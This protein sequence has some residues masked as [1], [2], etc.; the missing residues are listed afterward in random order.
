MQS[1][2][3][4]MSRTW[5]T[6]GRAA[7]AANGEHTLMSWSRILRCTDASAL[8]FHTDMKSC[9]GET[10]HSELQS[11]HINKRASR[12]EKATPNHLLG[13]ARQH[14]TTHLRAV[15]QDLKR[16]SV[17]APRALKL[18][19]R[20]EPPAAQCAVCLLYTSPSPRDR[21]KSRMPSSA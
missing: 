8:K 18:R 9:K 5:E 10:N 21:Q 19:A 15:V 16:Q 1:V 14:N 13:S 11:H 7:R 12:T 2:D 3:A 20:A 6:M 4:V 17:S